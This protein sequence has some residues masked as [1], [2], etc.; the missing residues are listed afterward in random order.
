MKDRL[1][2]LFKHPIKKVYF[3]SIIAAYLLV[4]LTNITLSFYTFLAY[5]QEIKEINT[6]IGYVLT[7]NNQGGTGC[8]NKIQYGNNPWG[9]LCT[10][11]KTGYIFGGWYTEQDGEGTEV[12]SSTNA[13]TNVT[14]YA[15]Y[16][17]NTLY[18]VLK[19]AKKEGTYAREYTGEH[20]D[21]MDSSLSTKKIYHWYGSSDTNGTAILDKNNVIF[22]NHCWQMIRTTDT[23]GVRLIYNGEV[24]NGKCLNTRGT[25]VGYGGNRSSQSLNGT[26]WYGTDYT[27]SNG[28]FSLSGTTSS[29]QVTSSNGSTV[30][31]TL[32]GKYTCKSTTQSGTCSTLY[33]IE[34]YY[35]G[36]N[37]YAIPINS[38]SNYSQFGEIS[39]N[40]TSNSPAYFG[41]MYNMVY[42]YSY[43]NY[44]YEAV[45]TVGL[46][47]STSYYYAD[48]YD[49]NE[50]NANKY[51]LTNPYKVNSTS[52]YSSLVGKYT[53]IN[54][55]ATYSN[56]QIYYIVGINSTS[57]YCINIENGNDLSY[58]TN[59]KYTYGDSYT[60]NGNGTYTINNQTTINRI[61]YYTNYTNVKNKYV[62]KNATNNT[63]ND[64]WHATNE[65]N[66]TYIYHIKSS[67]IY[68]YA[69]GFTYNNATHKYTLNSDSITFWDTIDSNNVTSVNTH[70]YTCFNTTGECENISY[71]Y[72]LTNDGIPFYINISN[73][74]DVNDAL[75]EMI[76]ANN[77][78]TKNSTIKTGIDAWYKKYMLPYDSY[79]DD[80]IYCNDR[81]VRALG[82]FKPDGGSVTGETRYLQ[83]KEYT[84]GSDLSCTNITDKFS[85][86]NSSAEL[87]YKVGLIS[88]PEMN[89]LNNNNARKTGQN[90]WLVSPSYFGSS[91]ASGRSV[92]PSGGWSNSGVFN[93]LGARPAVSLIPGMRYSSGDGS[94]ANPYV[95][96]TNN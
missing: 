38:N 35:S 60:D 61:D 85:V 25:H 48:S 3:F 66:T 41:Y 37:A 50:T 27:Y 15:L 43:K 89:L 80:T 40:A 42:P 91:D 55:S 28:T 7:Y 14:A 75:E 4:T 72:F 82:S 23:G 16:Y 13:T 34:S 96:D 52:D 10:P 62:C 58:Y 93:T 33:L 45:L 76:S 71:V 29:T 44:S 54:T 59:D 19:R 74:K 77:V 30:I 88:S 78:N 65:L 79:I 56:E 64:V 81:G 17:Q 32:V 70:H 2:N 24:E 18:D 95:V 11:T 5:G 92:V 8:T 1:N 36:Y 6:K 51:T 94:M 68:K 12:T 47:L 39:F 31:P 20:Q 63:C 86:S 46:S 9:E 21:S 84:T 49:Y 22:A 87:T 69:S 67:A 57:A 83:F 53:F 73:G 26:Y 90:Y